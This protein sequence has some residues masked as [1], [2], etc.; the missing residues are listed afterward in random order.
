[1]ALL[2]SQPAAYNPVIF[3]SPGSSESPGTPLAKLSPKDESGS[4]LDLTGYNAA[5]ITIKNSTPGAPTGV[6]SS[7][8]TIGTADA[9]GIEVRLTPAQSQSIAAALNSG[10]SSCWVEVGNGTD[11]LWASTG[12]L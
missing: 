5:T 8:M 10:S 1:M 2:A 3:Y 6:Y 11:T 7:G 12:S 9:T 4:V